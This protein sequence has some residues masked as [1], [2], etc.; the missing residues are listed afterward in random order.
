MKAIK[1]SFII[2][3]MISVAILTG[4]KSNKTD[5]HGHAADANAEIAETE[6]HG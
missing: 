4:C 2:L 1:F 5:E 6:S 3:I